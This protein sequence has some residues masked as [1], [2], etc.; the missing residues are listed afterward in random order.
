[1]K[2]STL[3]RMTAATSDKAAF[4]NLQ[5]IDGKQFAR[6]L[7]RLEDNEAEATAYIATIAA[8]V[9]RQYN[10]D[11][12]A[13]VWAG[14]LPSFVKAE[15]KALTLTDIEAAAA[16]NGHINIDTLVNKCVSR[17]DKAAKA[18]AK[19]EAAA[20]KQSQKAEDKA[21]AKAARIAK[22]EAELAALKSA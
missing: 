10:N 3:K 5:K 12:K 17:A 19:A 6:M 16:A 9:I 1:M 20:A 8:K 2:K 4:G 13:R 18:A 14:S 7:N 22:L 21:A 11:F 15:A